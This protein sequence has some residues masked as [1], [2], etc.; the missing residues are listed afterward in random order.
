MQVLPYSRILA[1]AAWS[2]EDMRRFIEITSKYG[3]NGIVFLSGDVHHANLVESNCKS[4]S[5]GY[6]LYDFTSSG[7]THSCSFGG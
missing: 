6:P 3:I 1:V 4:S 7:M 2:G 5:L